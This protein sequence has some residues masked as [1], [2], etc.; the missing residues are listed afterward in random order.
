MSEAPKAADADRLG[1]ITLRP[2]LVLP[3]HVTGELAVLVAPASEAARSM[4]SIASQIQHIYVD[5]GSRS[6]CFVGDERRNGTTVVAS[7]VAAAFA[8]SGQRTLLIET[9]F[10]APRIAAMLGLDKDKPGLSNWLSDLDHASG[11]ATY[12]QPAYPNLI[13]M[14]AGTQCEA[15]EAYL[16]TDFRD[17]IL[18]MSRIFEVVICDTPPM[19]NRSGALAVAS[20]VEHAIIVARANKT[21]LKAL[22]EFQDLLKQAGRAI[23]GTV[24]VDVP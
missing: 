19:A 12:L 2:S 6:F 22:L 5:A 7:N 17:L 11:W 23:D 13:V 15:G 3:T 14:T 21:R 16:S 18:E 10:K 8:Q 4:K 20:A 24:Y 9:N 1:A